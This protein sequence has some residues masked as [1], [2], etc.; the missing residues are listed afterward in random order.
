MKINEQELKKFLHLSDSQLQEIEGKR[1]LC[2]V[3]GAHYP[4]VVR[5]TLGELEEAGGT[6]A[7]LVFLGGTEKIGDSIEELENAY[8]YEVYV[9]EGERSGMSA[10]VSSA[11]DDENPDMVLDLSDE[12]ILDYKSRFE[13]ASATLEK[14]VSYMGSDFSFRPPVKLDVLEKPSVSIIGTGKR[15]GKTAVGITVSRLMRKEGFDPVVVCMGR[16]GPS[17]PNFVDPNELG[18]DPDTLIEVA[19]KG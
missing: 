9:G 7:A 13:L 4:P 18:M 16:G 10:L 6:I 2:L 15:I 11:I 17:E 3:D 14:E 12:P 8:N 19:E 5:W 1:L